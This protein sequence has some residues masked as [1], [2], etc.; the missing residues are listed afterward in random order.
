V[1]RSAVT[2]GVQVKALLRGT[3]S[4]CYVTLAACLVTQAASALANLLT[5]MK[6]ASPIAPP[7]PPSRQPQ[8]VY[9]GE[10]NVNNSRFSDVTFI[11]DG[12]PF[13]AHKVRMSRASFRA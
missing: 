3:L 7:P 9:L 5:K 4:A 2:C 12:E 6:M 8:G 10:D 13:H 1:W 11:V